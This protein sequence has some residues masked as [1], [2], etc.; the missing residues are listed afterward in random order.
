MEGECFCLFSPRP[1][2]K[3]LWS[4]STKSERELG[5]ASSEFWVK[6]PL[7]TM[8]KHKPKKENHEHER[9]KKKFQCSRMLNLDFLFPPF[10]RHKHPLF[11]SL[12]QLVLQSSSSACKESYVAFYSA[13]KG[14]YAL[15]I[16]KWDLNPLLFFRTQPDNSSTPY[17]T[18]L[19]KWYVMIPLVMSLY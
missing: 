17:N 12:F 14:L 7:E 5:T 8:S 6:A 9:W 1:S 19:K 4:P 10:P 3:R 2:L 11:Q 16:I 18:C 13:A 15:T